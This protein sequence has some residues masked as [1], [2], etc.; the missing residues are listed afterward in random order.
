MIAKLL[1]SD[2]SGLL[3]FEL[4]KIDLD[5]K[6]FS[7][8]DDK[9]KI[10]NDL[11][12]INMFNANS[13]YIIKNFDSLLTQT[14]WKNDKQ[15]IL[16]ILNLD[17]EITIIFICETTKVNVSN[18]T[19]LNIET[20]ELKKLNKWNINNF[21]LSVLKYLHLNLSKDIFN[22]IVSNFSLDSNLIFHELA[23]LKS[24]DPNS[25]TIDALPHI[26]NFG[27]ENKI[28]NLINMFLNEDNEKLVIYLREIDSMKENFHELFNIFVSQLFLL[29]LFIESYAV[30]PNFAN[31]ARKFNIP[32]FQVTNWS[33]FIV[34]YKTNIIGNLINNLLKLEIDVIKNNKDIQLSFRLFLISGVL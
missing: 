2:D 19:N 34:K 17:V 30:D 4:K 20:I 12:Q 8:P 33:K 3:D 5:K 18:I 16:D 6:Y 13:V 21:V 32:A 25:L 14:N 1:Y 27:S 15:L 28:F 24:Y 7:W 11:I 29:K 31:I 9:E 10:F 26:L 23:K 22:Y